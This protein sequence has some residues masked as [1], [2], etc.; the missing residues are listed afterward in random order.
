MSWA[1][2]SWAWILTISRSN[3]LLLQLLLLNWLNLT[4]C[5]SARLNFFIRL[6]LIKTVIIWAY[7]TRATLL[8]HFKLLILPF[9]YSHPV[10]P[11]PPHDGPPGW[12]AV[13]YIHGASLSLVCLKY[14]FTR[15]FPWRPLPPPPL[16]PSVLPALVL[17]LLL[18]LHPW[19]TPYGH[20]WGVTLLTSYY[21]PI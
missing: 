3:L 14:T 10:P 4:Y 15:I 1:L 12:P 9:M 19:P 17:L 21:S 18:L 20:V 16:P 7:F 6:V 11:P 8:I 13:W 5:A 2:L